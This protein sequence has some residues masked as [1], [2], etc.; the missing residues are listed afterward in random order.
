MIDEE[1]GLGKRE[2]DRD[3]GFAKGGTVG[4]LMQSLGTCSPVVRFDCIREQARKIGVGVACVSD[5]ATIFKFIK[6]NYL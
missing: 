2:I 4:G 6:T 3:I 5:M 1:L